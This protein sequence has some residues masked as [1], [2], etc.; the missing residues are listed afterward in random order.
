MYNCENVLRMKKGNCNVVVYNYPIFGKKKKQ[1][2]GV[3]FRKLLE[4]ELK[5][6]FTWE[7]KKKK[8]EIYEHIKFSK[9][10]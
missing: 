10:S 6:K 5:D 8:I 7:P 1:V 4:M 9:S 2:F 3:C